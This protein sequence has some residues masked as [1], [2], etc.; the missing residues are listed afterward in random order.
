MHARVERA[1][2]GVAWLKLSGVPLEQMA[3]VGRGYL[4]TGSNGQYCPAGLWIG[5]AE[6]AVDGFD[7]LKV[8][9]PMGR[10]PRTAEVLVGERPQ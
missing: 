4:F 2:G 5:L 8:T 3:R 6:P 10:G 9:V 7:Y 1:E